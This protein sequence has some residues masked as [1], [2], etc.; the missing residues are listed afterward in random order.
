MAQGRTQWRVLVKTARNLQVPYKAENFLTRLV[1]ISL[2][3]TLLHGVSFHYRCTHFEKA[4]HGLVGGKGGRAPDFTTLRS[5][6]VQLKS[7]TK[8]LP[9]GRPA[10][11]SFVTRSSV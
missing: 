3:R 5:G 10:T 7:H 6:A 11:N 2:S 4:K 8:T 9:T 1:T